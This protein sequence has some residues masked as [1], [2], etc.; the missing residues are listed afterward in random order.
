[1]AGT[2]AYSDLLRDPRWQRM[3][4]EVFSRDQW[5]CKSC[6]A[7]HR[8]LQVHHKRYE[9]GKPPWEISPTALVTLCDE[10]HEKITLLRRRANDL[11]ADMAADVLDNTVTSLEYADRWI[12]T[13]RPLSFA[14]ERCDRE[15]SEILSRPYD[16]AAS[17][18]LEALDELTESI[19]AVLHADATEAAAAAQTEGVA[20]T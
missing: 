9:R 1:M 10:C 13:R 11:L 8:E 12:S 20:C 17:R 16:T 4:L 2:S 5:K 15:R 18:R 6:G 7:A 3:R 19:W 14:L